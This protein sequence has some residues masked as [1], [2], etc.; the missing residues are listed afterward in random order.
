M[1]EEESKLTPQP[2]AVK[3][4]GKM[5]RK[6]SLHFDRVPPKTKEAFLNLAH[7]EFCGDYGMTLKW[8]MDDL[9]SQDT[10]LAIAQLQ[11]HEAR[12]TALENMSKPVAELPADEESK[13]KKMA[14]GSMRRTKK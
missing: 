12:I 10:R 3:I 6:E 11:N 7:E 1:D 8:L 2:H 4:M 13:V 9:L 5:Q 14:D